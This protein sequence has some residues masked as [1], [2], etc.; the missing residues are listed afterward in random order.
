M[1]HP[2]SVFGLAVL[3]V[4]AYLYAINQNAVQGFAVR[5]AE[6]GVA[7]ARDE[8]QRLRIEEAQ[9]KSLGRIMEAKDRARLVESTADGAST[10][11]LSVGES[12]ALR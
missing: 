11:Y 8:N 9:L 10:S 4:V 12:L 5:N 1:F 2:K 3:F 7:Q 6:R